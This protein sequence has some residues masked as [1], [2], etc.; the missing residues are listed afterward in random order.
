MGSRTLKVIMENWI[1]DFPTGEFENFVELPFNIENV[2]RELDE[3]IMRLKKHIASMSCCC[4]G[5]TKHNL[6]LEE[7]NGPKAG[8]EFQD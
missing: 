5:C 6:A 1:G 4:A 7:N 8:N 2:C 3:E